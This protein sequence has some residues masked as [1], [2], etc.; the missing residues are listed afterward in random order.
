MD[1][2]LKTTQLMLKLLAISAE[3]TIKLLTTRRTATF[4]DAK[5]KLIMYRTMF[6]WKT[7]VIDFDQMVTARAN[8]M[9]IG[10]NGDSTLVP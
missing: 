2:H 1:L 8:R 3:K 7:R 6:C 10:M 5:P 4:E 9:P